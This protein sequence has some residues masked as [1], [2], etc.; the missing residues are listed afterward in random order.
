[1]AGVFPYMEVGELLD[2][3][4]EQLLAELP[5]TRYDGG[6]FA[7]ASGETYDATA[8]CPG[9]AGATD[10][11]ALLVGKSN[12]RLVVAGERYGIVGV[13][14]HQFVGQLELQLKRNLAA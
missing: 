14:R 4:G 2:V 8:Y 9:Q 5:L 1:M 10:V 7:S 13:V 3:S 11:A 12:R 6:Q